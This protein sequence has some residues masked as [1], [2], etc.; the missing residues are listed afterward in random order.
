MGASCSVAG[1]SPDDS[2]VKSRKKKETAVT[3]I[4][5]DC[6]SGTNERLSTSMNATQGTLPLSNA[7]PAFQSTSQLTAQ[8]VDSFISSA[9]YNQSP[10]IK[11]RGPLDRQKSVVSRHAIIIPVADEISTAAVDEEEND[12]FEEGEK[13]YHCHQQGGY[14]SR[15]TMLTIVNQIYENA[16]VVFDD[17]AVSKWL[18]TSLQSLGKPAV[19]PMLTK[20]EFLVMYKCCKAFASAK[21]RRL[22]KDNLKRRHTRTCSRQAMPFETHVFLGGSCN[23]TSWRKDTAI[24]FLSECSISCY[25]PQTDDWHPGLIDIEAHAKDQAHTLLFVIDSVTRSLA[26]MLEATEYILRGRRVIMVIE[27]M[28]DGHSIDDQI[29]TGRQ[30]KDLNRAR[31]FLADIVQRHQEN[32]I[33]CTSL[34]E[35]LEVIRDT[36][37]RACRELISIQQTKRSELLRLQTNES[38]TLSN[39]TEETLT[40]DLCGFIRNMT[41]ARESGVNRSVDFSECGDGDGCDGDKL[42]DGGNGGENHTSSSLLPPIHTVAPPQ[43]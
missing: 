33:L 18:D 41:T 37:C 1:S 11:V 21:R 40:S 42:S 6:A 19:D 26:S 15:Q 13:A 8:S 2:S 16:G 43:S 38:D 5:A 17:R 32:A 4:P 25:N 29:I 36:D 35:A 12:A 30:L 23:P 9:V 7:S 14:I 20:S 39:A 22:R 31:A 34:S 27:A 24:P 10:R 3:V 28:E